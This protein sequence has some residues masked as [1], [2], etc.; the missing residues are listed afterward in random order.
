MNEIRTLRADEIECRVATVKGPSEK[1][2]GGCSL[3]LYKDAR[4]DMR[5]LDEVFGPMNWMRTHE[6][7]GGRLYC[8]IAVR[9]PETG[10]WVPKQDV[11]TESYTE[12]EKGQA[13]DSFKRAG[14]NWGIGR[15]LYTAPF[16]WVQL[17][18]DEMFQKGQNW[19]V[20][21]SFRVDEIDYNDRHEIIRLVI[22]DKN[23]NTRFSME[24]PDTAPENPPL[25]KKRIGEAQLKAMHS[26]CS[27]I[28][29][30]KATK[31]EFYQLTGL[32]WA[33]A[34][35]LTVEDWQYTMEVL[36]KKLEAKMNHDA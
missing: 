31:G 21:T 32:S 36:N 17:T 5:I 10:N 28:L 14:F 19:G 29:G 33:D 20:K 16:I 35:K 1:K 12:K 3:L 34:E 13:S 8:S 24:K 30:H 11:G 6:E 22:K 25:E 27:E 15:E 23:G 4:C 18:N 7:I 9:D 2:S 26:L